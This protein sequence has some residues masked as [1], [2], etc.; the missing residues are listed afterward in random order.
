[1]AISDLERYYREQLRLLED[2]DWQA[3]EDS[4]VETLISKFRSATLSPA[5]AVELA[6]HML[7]SKGLNPETVERIARRVSDGM[8]EPAQ[9]N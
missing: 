3:S 7:G 6:R 2:L 9:S 1:M 4:L 8:G 5:M